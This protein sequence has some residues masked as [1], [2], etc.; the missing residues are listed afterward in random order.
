MVELSTTDMDKASKATI[1]T[2]GYNAWRNVWSPSPTNFYSEEKT[3]E[4][5]KHY[6]MKITHYEGSGDDYVSVGFKINDLTAAKPNSLKG[7]KS[8]SIEPNHV[9]EKFEVLLPNNPAANFRIQ[10]TNSRLSC[11]ALTKSSDIF[12]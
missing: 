3:L 1:L 4:A 2:S 11:S 6:Y 9:F 8:V 12:Q 10:F 7:W 5:G